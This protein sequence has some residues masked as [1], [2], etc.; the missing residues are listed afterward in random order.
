MDK[1][2]KFFL[3][4]GEVPKVDKF[5]QT[6]TSANITVPQLCWRGVIITV[7]ITVIIVP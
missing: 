6:D 2:E 1:F 7:I 4:G 3:G 5:E